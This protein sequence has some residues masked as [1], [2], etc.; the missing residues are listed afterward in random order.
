MSDIPTYPPFQAPSPPKSSN[1]GHAASDPVTETSCL[2][3]A[4]HWA[5][6]SPHLGLL[7]CLEL[8]ILQACKGIRENSEYLI[9]WGYLVDPGI[10]RIHVIVHIAEFSIAPFTVHPVCTA[11]PEAVPLLLWYFHTKHILLLLV[12]SSTIQLCRTSI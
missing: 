6:G 12:S 2:V 7:G 4:M 11:T 3:S 5:L 1:S 10:P 9:S 8:A